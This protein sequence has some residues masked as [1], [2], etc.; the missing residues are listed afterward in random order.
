M[1]LTLR[2][3]NLILQ[4]K[5]NEVCVLT[6]EN[7]QSFLNILQDFDSQ[8]R[9]EDGAIL[10]SDGEIILPMVNQVEIIWNPLQIDFNAKKILG[11]LYQEMKKISGEEC[12]QDFQMIQQT[13]GQ[14][15]NALSLKLSYDISYSIEVDIMAI[16]KLCDVKL[17]LDGI[18]VQQRLI[19]YIKLLSMLCNVKL[20]IFVNIK[21]FLSNEQ[22][23]E[24]YKTAFY[25]KINVLLMESTQKERLEGEKQYILDNFDCLIELQ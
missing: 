19:E 5:E 21:G 8:C 10:L 12:C 23:A 6:V 16:Y 24:L 9:G 22:I 2:E 17:D 11:R 15:L 13:M 25:Y 1:K 7:P 20:L 14:Y 3:Y 4:L 18:D